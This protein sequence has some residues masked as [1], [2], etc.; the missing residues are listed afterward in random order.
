MYDWFLG[1]LITVGLFIPGR[2]MNALFYSPAEIKHW[3]KERTV[4]WRKELEG[5]QHNHQLS[6]V[7]AAATTLTAGERCS[8]NAH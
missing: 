3:K 7:S 8:M 2:D 5:D 1:S 4:L 6:A